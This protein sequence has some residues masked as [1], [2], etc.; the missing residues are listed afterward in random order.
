VP[1]ALWGLWGAFAVLALT[2]GLLLPLGE[3]PDEPGHYNYARIVALEQR[4]PRG[5]EEH[6]AFQP[7]LYYWL[8]APMASLGDP[9]RLPLKGNADFSLAP[10][11]PGNLLLHT[12]EEVFPWAGWAAGWHLVRLCSLFAGLVTVWAVLRLGLLVTGRPVVAALSVPLLVLTPAFTLLHGAASNDALALALG[13]VLLC[14]TL[15][16]ARGGA[17]PRRLASVGLLWGLAVLAKASLLASGGGIGAA[18]FVGWLRRRRRLSRLADDGAGVVAVAAFV[19]GWWLVRN[20]RL[21]GDPLGW[22]LIFAINEPRALAV[23]WWQQAVGLWRSYWLGYVALNLP[24]WVYR[25]LLLLPA[26]ALA[27][28]AWRARRLSRPRRRAQS[29]SR[30]GARWAD[31]LTRLAL[32]EKR[33]ALGPAIAVVLAVHVLAY[34]ASWA[35]WTLAVGGT[36]QARLLY[37][38]L[39]AFLPM[40]A[41]G[42]VELAPGRR[43][44]LLA[45]AL[46]GGIIALN[47]YALFFRVLPVYAPAPRLQESQVSASGQR[48]AFGRQVDLLAYQVQ[49]S[50]VAG[51]SLEVLT[52]WRLPRP[53]SEDL[54]LTLRLVAADGSVPVWKQGTPSAGRDT[55]DRWPAGVAIEGRHYLLLP[56]DL[57]PGRYTLEAGLRPFGSN[58]WLLASDG[59]EMREVWPLATV[60]VLSPRR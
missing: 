45:A 10:E 54:W 13:S 56:P 11:G 52:W 30:L 33:L 20:W 6:E 15:I 48:V 21:Y 31:A 7:P 36:D 1:R 2:Y 12:R 5:E 60:E 4:L 42:L 34:L 58:V 55:T 28:L 47:L 53:A 32:R 3:A 37:P 39:I 22:R 16:V 24:G 17:S 27:G 14:E 51:Q 19:C 18:V 29:L 46:I 35:R 57:A 25:A 50:A 40:A 44:P 9:T 8:A 49:P 38:A 41:A 23:D 59:G 43:R 26:L